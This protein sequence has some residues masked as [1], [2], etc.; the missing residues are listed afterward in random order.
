MYLLD[1]CLYICLS[2][3]QRM[4]RLYGCIYLFIY[5]FENVVVIWKGKYIEKIGEM[6]PKFSQK[7]K[8]NSFAWMIVVDDMHLQTQSRDHYYMS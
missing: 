3:I 2:T 5:F 8:K 1:V 4:V 6:L 7:K